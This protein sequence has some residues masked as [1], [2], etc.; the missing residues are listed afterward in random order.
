MSCID[1][2][3]VDANKQKWRLAADHHGDTWF[4]RMSAFGRIFELHV[5]SQSPHWFV[6]ARNEDLKEIWEDWLDYTRYNDLSV[7]QIDEIKRKHIERFLSLV[8]GADD[9]RVVRRGWRLRKKA[10]LLTEGTWKEIWATL[11]A[12]QT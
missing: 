3:W 10:E 4:L 9:F 2:A 11:N 1:E 6:I 7:T 8:S 5:P 12:L